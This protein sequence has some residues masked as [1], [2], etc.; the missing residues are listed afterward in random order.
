M[1]IKIIDSIDLSMTYT[2]LSLNKFIEV[3]FGKQ[4]VV[5]N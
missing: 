2:I 3:T 4:L 1:K 5:S